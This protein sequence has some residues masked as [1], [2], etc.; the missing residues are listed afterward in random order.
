MAL[1]K[2]FFVRQIKIFSK[3]SLLIN[4]SQENLSDILYKSSL[5]R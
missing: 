4:Y 2:D 3:I 1:I 5:K